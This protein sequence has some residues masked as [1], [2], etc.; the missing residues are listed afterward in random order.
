MGVFGSGRL[1]RVTLMTPMALWPRLE[2]MNHFAMANVA[3][4]TL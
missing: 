1:V 3:D 2:L 4:A